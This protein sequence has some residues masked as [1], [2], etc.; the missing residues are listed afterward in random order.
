MRKLMTVL[1]VAALA[2]SAFAKEEVKSLD[3]LHERMKLSRE[4]R[5]KMLKERTGGL[6]VVHEPGPVIAVVDSQK[7]VGTAVV[8]KVVA[9]L[10]Q[11]SRLPVDCV[12]ETVKDPV[13]DAKYALSFQRAAVIV[14]CEDPD[15]PVMLVAPEAKWA[16]MNVTRLAEGKPDAETLENRFRKELWRT[17]GYLMG[18]A[19]SMTPGCLLSSVNDNA[20]LD[21]LRAETVCPEPFGKIYNVA[22]KYGIPHVKMA[23][24]RKALLEG[25]A[26]PPADEYQKKIYEDFK[27]GKLEAPKA[28]GKK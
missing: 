17:F 7:L 1:A 27:A 22:E 12:K 4:E 26:P 8:A 19:H 21:R 11:T 25:W 14:I 18:A 6:V 10:Q 20:D 5:M 15:L 13:R 16:V 2:A 24:Y 28:D 3:K 9:R 23:N